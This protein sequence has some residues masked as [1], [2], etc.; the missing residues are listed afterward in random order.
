MREWQVEYMSRPVERHHV[1]P[2][3]DFR[4]ACLLARKMSDKFDGSA[5][6]TALDDRPEGGKAATGHIE[7]SFGIPTEKVGCLSTVA[8]P[9][10]KPT[11][12]S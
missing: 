10:E 2:V 11:C 6:V 1:Q 7:F 3:R 9:S 8:I 5:T 12:T 4:E